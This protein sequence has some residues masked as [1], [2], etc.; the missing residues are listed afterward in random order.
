MNVKSSKE[1]SVVVSLAMLS[2]MMSYLRREGG[3]IIASVKDLS[4][5]FY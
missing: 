4:N 2:P 1:N 3:F 5:L